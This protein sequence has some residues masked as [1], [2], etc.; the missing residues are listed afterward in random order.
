MKGVPR[1]QFR[2][3]LELTEEAYAILEAAAHRVLERLGMLDTNFVTKEDL[4]DHCWQATFFYLRSYEELKVLFLRARDEMWR[5]VT[6]KIGP[7]RRRPLEADPDSERPAFEPDSGRELDDPARA[8]QA[9][10]EWRNLP[11]AHRQYILESVLGGRRRQDLARE[12]QER[13]LAPQLLATRGLL[14]RRERYLVH[15]CMLRGRPKRELAAQLGLSKERIRQI[16]RSARLKYERC[17]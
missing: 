11:S 5:Y 2:A 17:R 9:L 13:E 16:L 4:I 3:H 6:R 8:A 12:R 15:Q 1:R 7:L 14:T 10:D